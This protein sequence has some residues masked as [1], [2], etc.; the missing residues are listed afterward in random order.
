MSHH[1][2]SPQQLILATDEHGETLRGKLRITVSAD[3]FAIKVILYLKN[4]T[5]KG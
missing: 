4:F 3:L 5:E 1:P 2:N